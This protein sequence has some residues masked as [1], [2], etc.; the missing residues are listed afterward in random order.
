M[1]TVPVLA[2][3]AMHIE[4]HQQNAAG[5]EQIGEIYGLGAAVADLAA[6]ADGVFFGAEA[7][8]ALGTDEVEAEL[9]GG[10]LVAGEAGAAAA[11][12]DDL[13]VSLVAGG[14][15]DAPEGT[16]GGI[17]GVCPWVKTPA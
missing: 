14:V 8:F 12:A 2:C 13:D 10:A 5:A 16:I 4:A 3:G 11:G 17:E 7:R 15:E 6:D 9:T 1:R